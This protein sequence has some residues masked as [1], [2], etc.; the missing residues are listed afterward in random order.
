MRSLAGNEA[1]EMTLDQLKSITTI[2]DGKPWIEWTT[3]IPAPE[4]L[5]NL[6]DEVLLYL[7]ENLGE[8]LLLLRVREYLIAKKIERKL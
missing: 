1:G 2:R 3:E 5:N 7:S 8:S 6:S 4:N